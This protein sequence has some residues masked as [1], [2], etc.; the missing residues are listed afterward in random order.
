MIYV[1]WFIATVFIISFVGFI[2]YVLKY[3]VCEMIKTAGL[4]NSLYSFTYIFL[5]VFGMAVGIGSIFWLSSYY[6]VGQ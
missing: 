6:G 5:I 2:F 1:A 3:V 4:K